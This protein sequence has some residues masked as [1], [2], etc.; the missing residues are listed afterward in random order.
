M[1]INRKNQYVVSK[2]EKVSYQRYNHQLQWFK[3][4]S[5]EYVFGCGEG[6]G[7][8]Q[9]EDYNSDY[10][11][12]PS[13]VELIGHIILN[14]TKDFGYATKMVVVLA[15]RLGIKHKLRLT[16]HPYDEMEKLRGHDY[17]EAIKHYMWKLDLVSEYNARGGIHMSID[18]LDD[19][20]FL[21]N[22]KEEELLEIKE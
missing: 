20:D 17:R 8:G 15:Y 6:C 14:E 16:E 1:F 2:G 11:H 7:E 18:N 5:T 21:E 9:I 12:L 19:F 10:D 3:E 22:F 13:L 4:N